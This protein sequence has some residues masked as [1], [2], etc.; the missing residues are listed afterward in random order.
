MNQVFIKGRALPSVLR[1]KAPKR[2]SSKKNQTIKRCPVKPPPKSVNKMTLRPNYLPSQLSGE[3]CQAPTRRQAGCGVR[4]PS[5]ES[6][7]SKSNHQGTAAVSPCF[8]LPGFNCGYLLLTHTHLE[9]APSLLDLA[10]V[11][12]PVLRITGQTH[13]PTF[14]LLFRVHHWPLTSIGTMQYLFTLCCLKATQSRNLFSDVQ[15]RKPLHTLFALPP[16]N[17][18]PYCPLCPG[19]G[20]KPEQIDPKDH[21]TEGPFS[22]PTCEGTWTQ[23]V[24][25]TCFGAYPLNTNGSSLDL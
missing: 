8:H 15:H 6:S 12:R 14:C 13:L 18:T 22:G 16:N 2:G 9:V 10:E 19:S 4:E 5:P 25:L 24:R 11:N 20:Q 3:P 21:H 23:K 7:G 1:F 17:E